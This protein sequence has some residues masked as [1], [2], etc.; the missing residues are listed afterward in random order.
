MIMMAAVLRNFKG[1]GWSKDISWDSNSKDAL[2][3]F[4]HKNAQM[5]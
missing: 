1:K 5:H 3:H 2:R 4:P